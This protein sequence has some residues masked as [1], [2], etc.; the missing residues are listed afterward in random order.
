MKLELSKDNLPADDDIEV[1][2]IPGEEADR[3]AGA[4]RYELFTYPA[5]YTL[6]VLNQKLQ[7]DEIEIPTLQ[8][9]FVWSQKQASRL[10]ESFLLGLP[11]PPVFMY[12]EKKSETLMVVD[13]Q[14]RLRS[15]KYFF[16]G[17]FG[18]EKLGKKS[19]F[20][21][22]IDDKSRFNGLTFS[23]LKDEDKRLLKRQVLRAFVMKQV[24]PN[25]NSSIFHVFER[26]NTGGTQLAN[27]EVRNCV[28]AGKF[29]DLLHELNSL[30]EWRKIVGKEY[31][32][33]RLRDMELVLRFI[34]LYKKPLSDY[35]KPM[36]DFLTNFMIAN[37]D[38]KNND[39]FENIFLQ[40]SKKVLSELGE[41]PFHI[42]AGLNTAVYDSVFCAFAKNI[43]LNVNNLKQKY[44]ALIQDTEFL[45]LTSG[46]TT[47]VENV[48]RRFAIATDYLFGTTDH[49]SA[50][51]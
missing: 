28:Y 11:V 17:S 45:A 16:D 50:K 33:K 3:T 19:V 13:G 51:H 6:E 40:T 37:R 44:D 46:S 25:D 12:A 35:L 48:K 43:H 23:D 36:K 4:T 21:L 18:E 15:I 9:R 31:P 10:I 32:D 49:D 42:K 39:E 38:G 30:K 5:D 47:D 29:N 8:R 14:Q 24:D 2:A 27:Q 22:Q 20:R 34:A 41:K 1:E 26:L 7:T